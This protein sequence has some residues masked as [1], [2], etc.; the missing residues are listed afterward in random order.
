VC[1]V[2]FFRPNCELQYQ[3]R[4]N[5]VCFICDKQ[6]SKKC[7]KHEITEVPLVKTASAYFGTAL[8]K[9][10]SPLLHEEPIIVSLHTYY[11]IFVREKCKN[12]EN[13]STQYFFHTQ[14]RCGLSPARQVPATCETPTHHHRRRAPRAHRIV[15]CVL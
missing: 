15:S 8:V 2:R 12:R 13:D 4:R 11:E 7:K 3:I 5:Q 14:C 9:N 6:P 10:I 1:S